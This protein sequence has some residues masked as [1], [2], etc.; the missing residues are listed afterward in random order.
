MADF[1][2]NFP[3]KRFNPF[4]TIKFETRQDV[5]DASN[6]LINPLM[7][8][9]SKGNARVQLDCSGAHFTRPACDV[10]GFA[11][12]LWAIVPMVAGGAKFDH[13]D[14]Y[15]QGLVNGT[16]PEHPEYW[17]PVQDK[18]QIL[19]ELAAIGCAL[20]FNKEFLWDPLTEKEKEGVAKYLINARNHDY[21]ICNWRF[22]RVLV[23]LG[24]EAVGIHNFDKSLTEKFLNEVDEYYIQDGWYRDGNIPEA[25]FA[26]D[27]YNP[28][29]LHFYGLIYAKLRGKQDPE[30]SK[31]YEDRAVLFAKQ[32]VHMFD[33]DGSCVPFGRSLTYRFACGSFW[34]ALGLVCED[35]SLP[36][37][38]IKGLYLRHWRWW[39]TQP[40]CE[41]DRGVLTVGYSYPNRFMSESYNSSQSPYWAL[42][43][44]FAL[45]LPESHPFWRATEEPLDFKALGTPE[46]NRL[47]VLPVPGFVIS[48]QPGHTVM[49]SSGPRRTE[50]RH[51]AE[52]YQKFAY[53]TRYGFSV[54]S[55][56]RQFDSCV[57][58]SMI[59]FSDDNEH[60]RVRQSCDEVRILGSTIYS[61]WHPWDDVDVETFLIPSGVWQIRVHRISSPRK[62]STIEGG[63]ALP[64]PPYK[65]ERIT[66]SANSVVVESL[67]DSSA[68]IDLGSSVARLPRG[69]A[70]DGNTS[71]MF[72]HTVIA[73]FLGQVPANQ[74][75]TFACAVVAS[76]DKSVVSKA[77]AN[78]PKCPSEAQL[79]EVITKGE[80][81]VLF[82]T[83]SK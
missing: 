35:D 19:V 45:I 28:F 37:G 51:I 75:V 80:L 41:L 69:H 25:D 5:I 57:F 61:K 29:A 82:Q 20:S 39:A 26:I 70:P 78:P 53:S 79:N 67:N 54:E 17:G 4:A 8:A 18:D 12:P 1:A 50:M 56:S 31:R 52:K 23:D 38:Q 47:A 64:R 48:H 27:Y 73:Q 76:P 6:A 24:L 59:G 10:E 13:W 63:F 43:M 14:K 66:T 49:I 15:R 21:P 34:G 55:D 2:A 40:I 7:S 72:P 58:D 11:R 3:L 81:T 74:T 16:N 60:F 44:S 71:I 9:F 46:S 30:R 42:K 22:F 62:L 83:K 36:W 32:F 68:M 65:N 77:L 33:S